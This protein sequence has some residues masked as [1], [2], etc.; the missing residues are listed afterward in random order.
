MSDL[1]L[2]LIITVWILFGVEGADT[3]HLLFQ[4][5]IFAHLG[6]CPHIQT[7]ATSG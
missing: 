2:V 5:V 3:K 6:S 1:H 4:G 7:A